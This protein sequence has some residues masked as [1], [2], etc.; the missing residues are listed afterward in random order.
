MNYPIFYT[1]FP[2]IASSAAASGVEKEGKTQL[3]LQKGR[4]FLKKCLTL[5]DG[6]V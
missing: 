2:P 1:K 3:F 4:I 6:F 5:G